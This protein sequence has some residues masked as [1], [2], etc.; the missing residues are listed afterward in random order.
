MSE[1][2]HPN[3]IKSITIVG[4]TAS[5]KT[6]LSLTLGRLLPIEVIAADS[7]TVWRGLDVGTAKPTKFEQKQV[8]HHLIDIVGPNDK[9]TVFDFQ[10]LAKQ[11][12]ADIKSRN[13]LPVIVGGSGLYVDSLFYDYQFVESGSNQQLRHQL[14]QLTIEQLQQRIIKEGLPR[15]ENWKNKRYLIRSIEKQSTRPV[16]GE[17]RA[18]RNK[19]IIGLKPQDNILKER[20]ELRFEQMIRNRVVAEAKRAWR[21]YPKDHE[22]LTGN[23][24]QSLLPYLDKRASLEQV[25]QDFIKRDLKLAKKQ[26][27]WFK[28]NPNIVWFEDSE[29]ALG[30]LK[31]QPLLTKL[32]GQN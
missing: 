30:Y 29:S 24:Y 10:K 32:I 21:D 11:T 22:A 1:K 17:N 3:Q 18:I 23:I 31:S 16:K 7:K 9:F 26:T 25:R 8:K 28:R 15:P 2:I 13:K 6:Q 12:I 19:L 20:M 27:T 5:G 14:D 4:Q